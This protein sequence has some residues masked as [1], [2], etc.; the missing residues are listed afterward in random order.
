MQPN[1]GIIFP[2]LMTKALSYLDM[3]NFDF[4]PAFNL[5]CTFDDFD[6]ISQIYVTTLAP[7]GVSVLI[8]LGNLVIE[9]GDIKR[10][11]SASANAFL[12]LTFL[13][14]IACSTVIFGFFKLHKF[15][16]IGMTYVEA[17]ELSAPSFVTRHILHTH[18]R[19][20]SRLV[21]LRLSRAHNQQPK[22]T[23]LTRT[24][25]STMRRC[26]SSW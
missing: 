12:V 18:A 19:T 5:S 3:I 9:R 8:L 2:P 22:T 24:A 13:V 26:H 23:P 16:E 11:V 25:T 14:F 17:G 1:L 20:Q 6:Y 10:A 4:I 21:S 7:I 15:P